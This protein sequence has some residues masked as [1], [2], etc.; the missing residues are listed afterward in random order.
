MVLSSLCVLCPCGHSCGLC[1]V[2]LHSGLKENILTK[3]IG[4][5]WQDFSFYILLSSLIWSLS[6]WREN[7]YWSAV[8]HL[9][10]FFYFRKDY[11]S[12]CML[13]LFSASPL[14]YHIFL[15]LAYL[16][17]SSKLG[18]S[19]AHAVSALSKCRNPHRRHPPSGFGG[20]IPENG[21]SPAQPGGPETTCRAQQKWCQN[22]STRPPSSSYLLQHTW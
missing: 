5:Q 15:I 12:I 11:S 18:R 3:D 22:G 7:T 14:L 1:C 21:V 10:V 17:R 13:W 2:F 8:T 9:E 20:C 19:W 6:F 16:A 4:S